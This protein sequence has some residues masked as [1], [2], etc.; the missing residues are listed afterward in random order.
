MLPYDYISGLGDG[1]KKGRGGGSCKLVDMAPGVQV[2]KTVLA[3]ICL[4]V[5]T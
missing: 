2:I 1:R 5:L 3:W 4:V